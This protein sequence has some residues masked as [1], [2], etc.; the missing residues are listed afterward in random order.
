MELEELKASWNAAGQESKTNKELLNMLDPNRHPVLKGIRRQT[1]IEVSGWTLFLLCYYSML[2]GHEKPLLINLFLVASLLIALFHNLL[3]YQF[4]QRLI[5][6]DSLITS[7]A[8]YMKKVKWYAIQSVTL[9]IVSTAALLAFL[10][11]NITFTAQKYLL[12]VIVIS[13]LIF[14]TFLL[15]KLWVKRYNELRNSLNAFKA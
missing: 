15:C 1:I 5:F 2:D 11:Y 13:I 12:L 3:G 6:G 4:S 9:R 7:V 8:T 10:T 14:Q